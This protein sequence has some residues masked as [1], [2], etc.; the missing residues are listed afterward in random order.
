MEDS[1]GTGGVA[2]SKN[3]S[4]ISALKDVEFAEQEME[5]EARENEAAENARVAGAP[6][7]SEENA[8]TDQKTSYLEEDIEAERLEWQTRETE[9]LQEVLNMQSDVD[10]AQQKAAVAV[11]EKEEVQ[12]S[13]QEALDE[14]AGRL[15]AEHKARVEEA[16]EG[17]TEALKQKDQEIAALKSSMPGSEDGGVGGRDM[18]S[19]QELQEARKRIAWEKEKRESALTAKE[20]A[21]EE[22][23]TLR[24]KNAEIQKV[25]NDKHLAA[26]LESEQHISNLQAEREELVSIVKE[27]DEEL[28]LVKDMEAS[29]RIMAKETFATYSS[30]KVESSRSE[31]LHAE[32]A[33]LKTMLAQE[34]DEKNQERAMGVS[35]EKEMERKLASLAAE[36]AA[37]SR[38]TDST[39][40]AE[41][42]S[43]QVLTLGL[44]VERL[45]AEKSAEA[46]RTKDLEDTIDF[47]TDRE[48][49]SAA[50]WKQTE[51]EYQAQAKILGQQVAD[52]T[53]KLDLVEEDTEQ[54]LTRK[55]G[56]LGKWREEWQRERKGYESVVREKD[57]ALADQRSEYE[58]E[59]DKRKKEVAGSSAEMESLTQELARAVKRSEEAEQ[60]LVKREALWDQSYQE[61]RVE[62]AAV[63]TEKVKLEAELEERITVSLETDEAYEN[64]IEGAHR[65]SRGG[66]GE[67]SVAAL[68][69][70][71]AEA[72][73]ELE[74]LKTAVSS[75]ENDLEGLKKELSDKG[76]EVRNLSKDLQGKVS[77]RHM[78]IACPL[79]VSGFS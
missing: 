6:R 76:N 45:R 37:H 49:D 10:E 57:R 23:R 25:S 72:R 13:K 60:R 31:A 62:L 17:I 27:R 32:V 3:E 4:S 36:V 47:A 75:K 48:E 74:G 30:N 8:V 11:H 12:S 55:D 58:D 71:L 40:E 18:S 79:T 51:V 73:V 33:S 22:V 43:S 28:T 21:E 20:Y 56:E 14:Q 15:A 77:N 66:V 41:D 39:G 34:R 59:S 65:G 54:Q 63:V 19:D 68:E 35:R 50:Q 70:E 2:D 67:E 53:R 5:K 46:M 69:E 61:H 7:D 78:Y 64:I 38:N 1:R 42:L 24:K 29:A 9:L 26:E 44:Q 52:L 16:R